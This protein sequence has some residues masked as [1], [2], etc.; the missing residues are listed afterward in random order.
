LLGKRTTFLKAGG[1]P[2]PRSTLRQSK[3]DW[4]AQ[5][6]QRDQKYWQKQRLEQGTGNRKR[7]PPNI[8]FFMKL[9]LLLFYPNNDHYFLSL[10]VSKEN[11]ALFIPA[12]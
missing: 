3:A 7:L 11:A 12:Y 5:V 6:L 4:R 2:R 10:H 1:I 8:R 9:Y